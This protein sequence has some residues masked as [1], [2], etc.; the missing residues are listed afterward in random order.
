[1][2]YVIVLAVAYLMGSSNLAYFLSKL[3]KVDL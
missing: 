1:M 3:K 2:G